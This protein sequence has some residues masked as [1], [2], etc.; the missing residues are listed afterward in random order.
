[1][2]RMDTMD[3]MDSIEDR[4]HLRFNGGGPKVAFYG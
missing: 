2:D 4:V 1:M 3:I